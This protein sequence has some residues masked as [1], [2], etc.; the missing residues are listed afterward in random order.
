MLDIWIQVVPQYATLEKT[1]RDDVVSNDELIQLTRN[2]ANSLLQAAR[3]VVE[4]FE[5]YDNGEIP[6]YA[7]IQA[8]QNTSM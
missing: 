2:V 7:F 6:E 3:N 5:E 8:S 4:Y 1:Y